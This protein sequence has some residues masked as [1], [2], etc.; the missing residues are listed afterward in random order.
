MHQFGTHQN[1]RVKIFP[2]LQ[3]LVSTSINKLQ[4]I[5][6]LLLHL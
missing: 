1:D 6:S 4:F 2:K 3:K 5:Y